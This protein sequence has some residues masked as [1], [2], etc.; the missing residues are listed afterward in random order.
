MLALGAVYA[1][2]EMKT[3][4][5]QARYFSSIGEQLHFRVEP[6]DS[7]DIRYPSAGPYDERLGYSSL[8]NF[9]ERLRKL[10]YSIT[11]QARSSPEL[12]NVVDQGIYATYFE[13][14]QA[15]LKIFDRDEKVLFSKAYPTRI[16]SDFDA[17][18]PLVIKTLLFIENRELL[19]ERYP[20]LNPA[21]E[22][23]RFARASMELIARKLGANIKVAGGSTLA[24]QI[25]KYRHSPGGRTDSPAEKLRQMASASLRAYLWGPDTRKARRAIVQAYLNSMPLAAAPELGEVHGL[26]DG[27]SAWF[28][29]DFATVNS[30]L[31]APNIDTGEGITEKQALAYRQVLRLL[32]AQRRPAYYLLAGRADLETLA[33]SHLRLLAAH[34]IIPPALRDAALR[35]SGGMNAHPALTPA[36][37]FAQ[38]KTESVLRTRLASALG[39]SRMY[40]LDRLDLSTRSTIDYDIQQ[41]V[42]RALHELRDPERARAAGVLGSRLLNSDNDF[43]TA[44]L[45]LYMLWYSFCY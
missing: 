32:L 9:Q 35:V 11:A 25:E 2:R 7:H 34:G 12:L 18:P 44:Q 39:V 33:D 10:G 24:T 3:S 20:H 8:P 45:L 38:R 28:G 29:S 31:S 26:G 37:P 5:F 23:D 21:I 15:G 40:D 22:W 16:Y 30:L 43:G 17:I 41:A 4:D 6:G 42:T 1:A 36:P 14:T 13:K 27:L 19:D